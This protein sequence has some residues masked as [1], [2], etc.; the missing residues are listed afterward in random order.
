MI[1]GISGYQWVVLEESNP[2][3]DFLIDRYGKVLGQIIYNR[4]DL[5]DENF[6]DEYIEPKLSN[7][8]KPSFFNYLEE[9]A[10]KLAQSIKSN[11]RIVVYGDYDADGITSTS[12]LVNFFR[13]INAYCKYYIPSRFDEGY[14]LNREAIKGISEYADILIVV[15]SGTN[16]FDELLFAKQCGLEVY[17]LDHHEPSDRWKELNPPY[18]ESGISIINPKFFEDINPLFKHLASV[19]LS[20]YLIASLKKYFD[21]DMKLREFLDIVALGTVA[22]LVP[23]SFINRTLVKAGIEEINKKKRVGIKKLIEQAGLK[24][25]I[26]STDIGFMLGPRI[27]ASGR[28]SDA[29]K[30]VKLLT[31]QDSVKA[32]TLA[33][34]LE[35]LNRKRQKITDEVTTQAEKKIKLYN[36]ENVIVVDDENWHS[37]VIGIVAGRIAQ[38]YRLP[39]VILSKENGKAVGS[40]RSVSKVNIYKALNMCGDLFEKFGGHSAAAGLTIDSSKIDELRERLDYSVK[41]VAEEKPWA[42]KEVDMFLPLDYWNI[43][44]VKEI[45]KLEPFGEKNPKPKFLATNLKI[46]Y[47]EVPYKSL[48]VFT[49]KDQSAK[50]FVAKWWKTAEVVKYLTIG[51]II[52]IVYTPN[53]STYR[54]LESV[55]FFVDDIRIVKE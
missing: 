14:G 24:R 37:G 43:Q 4:K 50:T 55:E 19:G 40:A 11:K 6:S 3:P 33:V 17:V 21:P 29:R 53:I 30:A 51:Q 23:M 41:E 2:V 49:L 28:L 31:T 9:I 5:F 27:N 47:F 25:E 52:D 22:D 10:F 1:V 45:Y 7:L 39:T 13:K 35:N 44:R 34:E 26:M 32:Q 38:K 8:I 36:S 20:F 46:D 18:L 12:I 48:I 54:D 42:V 16:A 15:D